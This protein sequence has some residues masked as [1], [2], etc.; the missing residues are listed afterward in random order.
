MIKNLSII[1]FI[2]FVC[3]TTYCQSNIYKEL[4]SA[5][6]DSLIR[7]NTKNP[8]FVIMDV[9]TPGEY[10]PKHLVGAINKN[11]QVNFDQKLD[12]LDK[13]KTYLIH[14]QSG[15]R[16]AGAFAKMKT[17]NFKEVY[18]MKNGISN[19]I[20]AGYA[21][22]SNFSPKL[23]SVTDT[24]MTFDSIYNHS[25]DTIEIIV[26]NR[27]NDTLN[28]NTLT[29]DNPS[30]STDFSIGKKLLGAE[31]YIFHLFFHTEVVGNYPVHISLS[32]DGGTVYYDFNN[33]VIPALGV[34]SIDLNNTINLY[35]NPAL[36][37]ITLNNIT[38][39]EL[40]TITIF[41]ISGQNLKEIN[42]IGIENKTIDISQFNS[43]IYWISIEISGIKPV[44]IPFIKL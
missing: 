34:K 36:N 11:Y 24:I 30:F 1:S 2:L 35:P 12:S 6:S 16:S 29:I 27:A 25:F 5:Q 43:G 19:W 28:F 42:G 17:K 32:S 8:N 3:I 33:N 18:N 13:N 41:D 20:S 21:T 26:T 10:N 40:K 44:I 22:T 4:T 39:Q 38:D 14:C 37:T 15:S 23:M 7:A 31:D 9:R